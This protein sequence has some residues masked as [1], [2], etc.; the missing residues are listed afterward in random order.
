M[1]NP[2]NFY[3][4]VPLLRAAELR[5]DVA[6]AAIGAFNVNFYAQ[7]EGILEGLISAQAPG[8]IQASKGANQFQGG[9]DKIRD[10]VLHAM[11]VLGINNFPICLHLDHG[12]YESAVSCI[13]GGFSSVM[14]D[15]STKKSKKGDK[16]FE[17]K[18]NALENAWLTE[19]IVLAAHRKGISVEGEMGVL[20]GREEDVVAEMSIFPTAY[21]VEQYAYN[22]GVDAVAIACGTCHGAVKKFKGLDYELLKASREKL[23]RFGA[24]IVLHGSSTVPLELI[25]EINRYGGTI[26]EKTAGGVPMEAIKEAIR[27]GAR[28]I[29]IDTDLRLGITA[30]IRKYL[31]E[32]PDVER[33]S[34]ALGLIKAVFDGEIPAYEKDGSLVAPGSMIDP[35]SY[36]GALMKRKPEFLRENYARSADGAF[37][38]VMQLVKRR[39]AEHVYH[40]CKEF[41][42][43]GLANKITA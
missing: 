2:K 42:S 26:D 31:H 41:G 3:S 6:P 38:E 33:C 1:D 5:S 12:D 16:T 35:R 30:T 8:I 10:M 23:R 21:E 4:L 32:H 34:E 9:P 11:G 40:L 17:E 37:I 15:F 36:M 28:K 39:V 14:I 29:N 43:A 18:R 19:P 7:A 20:A 24:G 13:H 25:Q 27:C 22:S